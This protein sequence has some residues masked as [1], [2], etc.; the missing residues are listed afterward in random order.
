[1]PGYSNRHPY[2]GAASA[3]KVREPSRR[4]SV[5]LFALCQLRRQLGFLDKLVVF[6]PGA[7]IPPV[8]FVSYARA[9]TDYQPYR[10]DM[11]RF[12]DDLSAKVAVKM[13]IPR[14]GV[15][16]FDESSIETGTI[17]RSELADALKTTRVGVT[18]YSPSYFTSQ[19][20]GKEFQVFLNRAAADPAAPKSQIGIV[21]VLWMKCTTLPPSVQEIQ[22]KHDAFPREYLEVGVQQLLSLKVYSDHYQLS[23]EAIANGIVSTAAT[24]LAPVQVVDLQNIP[25]AWDRSS[26]ADPESHKEGAIA[27]TCFVFVSRQ[28][29]DWQPYPERRKAIGAMAQQI[30]GDLGLRYEEIVCDATLPK[31]LKE[32]R[33]SSVPT[34]LFGD[35]TSLLDGAYAQPMREYDE[36]YLLNCGALVPW[37]EESKTRGSN[38]G[39]WLH[40]KENVC[41]QKTKVPPPNHEW[42]SIFSQDDL[43]TKTRTI[44]E[45]IRL[46]L[47]QQILSDDRSGAHDGNGAEGTVA[48]ILKAEDKGL[49]DS[50]ATQGIRVESAPQIEGPSK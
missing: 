33:I 39:T 34:V 49:T 28:G 40:L 38:D 30:S 15:C 42:R 32:T 20:C 17:W 24:G 23:L 13:G 18:L 19:W 12:I 48:N 14:V 46:R 41:Q 27:K 44:I 8:F 11:Q 47:L 6:M 43:E 50:A 29:W 45:N 7:G 16:F 37:S 25:S 22:Y 3:T 31:K 5:G 21:P 35:P 2:K 1:M 9:D 26:A 36:L 10:N 4:S